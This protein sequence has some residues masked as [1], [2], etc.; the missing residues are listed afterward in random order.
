[1]H[2]Q[3]E[4]MAEMEFVSMHYKLGTLMGMNDSMAPPDFSRTF[5]MAGSRGKWVTALADLFSKPESEHYEGLYIRWLYPGCP[6]VRF[7][8]HPPFL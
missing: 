6:N 1:L 4:E 2:K 3:A 8:L 7:F 5:S